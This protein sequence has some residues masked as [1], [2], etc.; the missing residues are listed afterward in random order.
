[1]INGTVVQVCF[2]QKQ[3]WEVCGLVMENCKVSVC[4]KPLSEQANRDDSTVTVF[5]HILNWMYVSQQVESAIEQLTMIVNQVDALHAVEMDEEDKDF[6]D[7]SPIR[8]FIRQDD[9]VPIGGWKEGEGKKDETDMSAGWACGGIGNVG[10][11]NEQEARERATREGTNDEAAQ[12]QFMTPSTSHCTEES[13]VRIAP[14]S[15]SATAAAGV[16]GGSQILI[17]AESA[18]PRWRRTSVVSDS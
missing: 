2:L 6:T 11:A 9:A 15:S 8:R 3:K 17:A 16:V 5:F 12:G 18:T 14:S 4:Q 1:M 10:L 7:N 13:P